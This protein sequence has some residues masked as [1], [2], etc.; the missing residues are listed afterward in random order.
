MNYPL[1][2]LALDFFVR[3][4]IRPSGFDAGLN[5]LIARY[6]G[7]TVP[8]LYNLLD[9]HDTPRLLHL[10]SGDTER[11]KL[12]VG[13]QMTFPGAPAIYYGDEVGL[14][15]G[16]DPECR[17]TMIWDCARQNTEILRWYRRL[18]V[19]RRS[20]LSL[21]RGS[22]IS[23]VCDDTASVYGFL[24]RHGEEETCVILNN[25]SEERSVFVP[26]R[27]R[28]NGAAWRD[29]LVG[30]EYQAVPIRGRRKDRLHNSDIL[31]Y[32]ATVAIR[33]RGCSMSMLAAG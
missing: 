15:G 8:V 20:R 28:G 4:T 10:C 5:E 11:F 23:N 2:E 17:G 21:S 18:I 9:S 24:R 14:T 30:G 33:L 22:F 31:G 19:L 16:D 12:A 3:R 29:L 7:V 32:E 13:F 25:S 6:P 1:R 26:V 27:R